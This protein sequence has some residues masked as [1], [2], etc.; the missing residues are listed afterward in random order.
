[1]RSNCC[2]DSHSAIRRVSCKKGSRLLWHEH[3]HVVRH[4]CC[5][6][7][8]TSQGS[9]V[10]G[11]RSGGGAMASLFWNVCRFAVHMKTGGLRFWIFPETRFQKSAFSGA[12]FSGSV[13]M[14]G[15][16]YAIH[17]RFHKRAF[18]SGRPLI[19][20]AVVWKA[21]LLCITIN[22]DALVVYVMPLL[23]L[24]CCHSI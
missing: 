4:C 20:P 15:K 11:K 16:N 18:L 6:C 17:V 8:E 10:E 14:V 7:Y 2:C 12:A 3:E 5:C 19:L 13:W 9:E 1:M 22:F 23:P 24:G 21:L